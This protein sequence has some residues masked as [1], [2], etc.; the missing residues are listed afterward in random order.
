MAGLKRRERVEGWALDVST[1]DEGMGSSF[2][3]RL[4]DSNKLWV[5]ALVVVV[6]VAGFLMLN[7]KRQA[8]LKN[9]DIAPPPTARL[10]FGSYDD[11]PHS[12]FT[13]DFRRKNEEVLDARFEDGRFIIVVPGNASADDIDAMAKAAAQINWAK[14]KNRIVVEVY[15]RAAAANSDVLVC[16]TKWKTESFGFVSDFVR[17]E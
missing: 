15:Q 9:E 7:A 2:F 8:S 11:K 16:T 1:A 13:A 14:F 10:M 6:L 3:Q 17:A 4:A 5:A 12:Q